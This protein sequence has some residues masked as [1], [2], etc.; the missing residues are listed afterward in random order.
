MR[1]T[2]RYDRATDS[3]IEVARAEPRPVHFI[4]DAYAINP[5]VSP[6]DG[7]LIACRAD[8]RAH[9]RANN[10][11]DIGSDPAFLR[12]REFVPMPPAGPDIKAAWDAL[13]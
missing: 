4:Q 8:L 1:R 13:D 12:P 9:N 11:A 6:V 10:C 5:T 2:Y 3:M 7:S